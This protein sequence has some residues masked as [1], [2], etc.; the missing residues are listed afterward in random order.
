[1]FFLDFQKLYGSLS[2]RFYAF[3]NVIVDKINL[4][5]KTKVNMFWVA[6]LNIGGHLEC[7]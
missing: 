1:M 7:C 4:K 6:I 2:E 3:L 5:A